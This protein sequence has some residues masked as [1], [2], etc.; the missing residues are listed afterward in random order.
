MPIGIVLALCP[1]RCGGQGACTAWAGAFACQGSGL[2]GNVHKK[3]PVRAQGLW[4]GGFAAPGQ[5]VA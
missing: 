2:Q 4:G 1:L 3:S 5:G